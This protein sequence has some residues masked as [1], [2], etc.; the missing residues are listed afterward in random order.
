M[1]ELVRLALLLIL[2]G[3]GLTVLGGAAVWFMNDERRITRS[4]KRVLGAAAEA[5]VSAHGRGAGFAFSR[6]TMAV[7]WD[8]GAWCLVYRIGEL[9]GVEVLADGQVVGRAHQ[10]EPRRAID[11]PMVGAA[12][13]VLR[14]LFD[15]PAHPDF[16][17]VLWDEDADPRKGR[18]SPALAGQ[19]A[20][21][22]L[23]R[24]ESILRRQGAPA[25]PAAVA[26]RPEPA[27]PPPAPTPPV[28]A[29]E[30]AHAME[31]EDAG[32]KPPF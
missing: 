17:I 11:R 20:N 8:Q 16:E 7:T 27:P 22:W 19:E 3:A 26:Q 23:A 29:P 24:A 15:D 14:L 13:V 6:G 25:K 1:S 21:R 31:S 18:P 28:P 32:E 4:L 5:K 10:G 30:P 9:V 2:A 12:Q